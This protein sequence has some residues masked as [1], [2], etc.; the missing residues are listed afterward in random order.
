[1]S[2]Q[3]RTSEEPREGAPG[4]TPPEATPPPEVAPP[5]RSRP[6]R[7]SAR[8]RRAEPGPS[9]EAGRRV[10]P[11]RGGGRPRA[12]RRLD[13]RRPPRSRS[14]PTKRPSRARWAIA[15]L[16][17]LV[18]VALLGSRAV[19]PRRSAERR[20]RRVLDPVGRHG[21]PRG[22]RRSPRRP[23]PEPR[24]VPRPLPGLR[25][26]VHARHEDRRGARPAHQ[27][28]ERRQARLVE[29][30]Q[31]LVRR[32]GRHVGVGFPDRRAPTRRP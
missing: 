20:G 23:A 2:E 28:G 10:R 5:P 4:S 13:D 19:R 30:D 25:R 31:A 6:R 15:G 14:T 17:A 22:P 21:L 3:D 12:G 16:I 27:P 26:P 24:S 9:G 1:M 18:V 32:P 8:A 7:P 29:G 11:G